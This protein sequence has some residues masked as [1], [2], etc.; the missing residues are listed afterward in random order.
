MIKVKSIEVRE[1]EYTYENRPKINGMDDVVHAIKPMIADQNKEFFIAL[2]LNTKNGILKKQIISIGSLSANIV[3][4]RE[5]FRTAC[6]ISASSIIV[7]HNHP[8]GDPA[9]SREDIELTKRLSEAG[10]IIGIELLDHVIIGHDRNYGF[11]E[12]GQL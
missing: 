4:P 9:P 8:S 1:I 12:C 11:K 5:V 2:Y 3:H 10:K 6:M 7:A